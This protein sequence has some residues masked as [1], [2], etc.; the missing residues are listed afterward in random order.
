MDLKNAKAGG[1]TLGN[2][3]VIPQKVT[4]VPNGQETTILLREHISF[5]LTSTRNP[6][7]RPRQGA[8]YGNLVLDI[9]FTIIV[10]LGAEGS[11]SYSQLIS[12]YYQERKKYTIFLCIRTLTNSLYK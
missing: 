7:Y 3:F 12:P 8:A 11:N 6:F 10:K 2:Y 4:W 5:T 1:I 9:L